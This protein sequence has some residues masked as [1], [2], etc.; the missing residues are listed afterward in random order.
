MN[1]KLFITTVIILS[2]AL[3]I[4]TGVVALKLFFPNQNISTIS[5]A[6]YQHLPKFDTSLSNLVRE[7]DDNKE[8]AIKNARQRIVKIENNNV[9]VE[10][11][12]TQDETKNVEQLV[13]DYGG[14][15]T[16]SS[17]Q[18]SIINAW[19]PIEKLRLL[20]ESDKVGIIRQPQEMM[21]FNN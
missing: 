13:E 10:I 5:T 20:S 8:T 7:W 2:L 18:Y 12:V 17:E 19:V 9:Y 11:H 3:I 15:I 1:K 4:A 6:K 14:Q 16:F 21:H